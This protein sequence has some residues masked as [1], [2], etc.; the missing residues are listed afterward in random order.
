M[1]CQDFSSTVTKIAYPAKIRFLSFT[2]EDITVDMAFS[3]SQRNLQSFIPYCYNMV[4]THIKATYFLYFR[5]KFQCT[6]DLYFIRLIQR[7]KDWSK[8]SSSWYFIS[9]FIINGKLHSRVEKYFTRS[10]RSLV[11]YFSTLLEENVL[12]PHDHVTSSISITRIY[13]TLLCF[14]ISLTSFFLS[15]IISVAI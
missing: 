3:V 10:L 1:K 13:S 12:S 7:M 11:R 9:V 2:C 14:V 5:L 8:K 15:V 6:Q 4:R